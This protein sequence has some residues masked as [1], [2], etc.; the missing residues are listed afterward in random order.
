MDF[1]YSDYFGATPNTG[2][3]ILLYDGIMGIK[4]CFSERTWWKR[5]GAS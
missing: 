3:E 2:Y 1:N 5:A 4:P